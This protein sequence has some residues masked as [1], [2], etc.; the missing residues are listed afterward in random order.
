[1]ATASIP[2]RPAG[3]PGP[4]SIAQL[5]ADFDAITTF[6]NG[7][8]MDTDNL[9]DSLVNAKLGLNKTGTTRRGTA[10]VATSQTTAS[11]SITDLATAGPSVTVTVAAGQLVKVFAQ[12]DMSCTGGGVA[13]CSLDESATNLGDILQTP[14]AVQKTIWTGYSG[15]PSIPGTDLRSTGYLLTIVPVGTGARVFKMR[16]RVT[17]GTGTFLSRKLW[18]AV[19][20]PS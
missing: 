19:Y 2:N 13:I 11:T 12:C 16:Y 9:S 15:S 5:L 10:S 7:G 8:T 18:V 3:T 17:A 14:S 1:M 4:R 20:D 6:L